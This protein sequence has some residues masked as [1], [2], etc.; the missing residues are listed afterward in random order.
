MSETKRTDT[1]QTKTETTNW[2]GDKIT[3]TTTETRVDG[4]KTEG[5][6]NG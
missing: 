4:K 2:F 6:G 3:K 5:G 1:K